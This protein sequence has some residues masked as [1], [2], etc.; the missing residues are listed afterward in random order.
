MIMARERRCWEVESRI[1][2]AELF[3]YSIQVAGWG[4]PV[5]SRVMHM[6]TPY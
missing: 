3:S 1:P 5:Y 2:V 4:W 6:D